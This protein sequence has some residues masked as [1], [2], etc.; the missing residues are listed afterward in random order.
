[1]KLFL[2]TLLSAV[3][4]FGAVDINSASAKELQSVKGIGAKKAKQIVAFRESECFHSV[5]D[6]AKI[7]GIGAKTVKKLKPFLKAGPCRK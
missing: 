2:A 3:A 4:L 5:D 1:M 7:K 6:L